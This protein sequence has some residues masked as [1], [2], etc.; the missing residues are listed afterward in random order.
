MSIFG[1]RRGI[2]RTV[3]T[4][5]TDRVTARQA[6]RSKRQAARQAT[7]QQRIAAKGASGYW[8]PEAVQARQA[9]IGQGIT[10]GGSIASD[11]IQNM[12]MGSGIPEEEALGDPTR[13][14]ALPAVPNGAAN[15]LTEWTKDLPEWFFPVAI[16]AGVLYFLMGQKKK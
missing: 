7:R 5:R 10:T 1:N 16:G 8:S 12:Q 15:G 3:V 4:S 14:A 6:A 2:L 13:G 11:F 9:T